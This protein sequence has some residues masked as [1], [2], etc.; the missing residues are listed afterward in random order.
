MRRRFRPVL[1]L[2]VAGL[3]AGHSLAWAAPPRSM[4]FHKQVAMDRQGFGI[5]AFRLLVPEK[6]RFQGGVTWDMQKFP[7]LATIAFK[8]ASPDG[9]SLFEHF[10]H[11]NFFWSQDPNLQMS[12]ART[13]TE[14]MAPVSAVDF[15]RNVFLPRHRKDIGDLKVLESAALPELARK[16][17]EIAEHQMAL[18][19]TISPFTFRFE[20]ASDAGHLRVQ[21][22][23][24]GRVIVEE[25]TVA[26]TRMTA[27]LQGM[28]GPVTSVTWIT[29]VNS[30]QAPAEEMAGRA[31]L[32]RVMLDS[33]LENPAWA[34]AGTRLAATVTREQLRHQQAVF[35]RMQQI[36][37]S[38]QEVSDMIV[39]GYRQRSAAQDRIF[40]KYSEA[41][42]GVDTYR[43]PVND[44]EIQL[45]TG[46]RNAWTDGSEYVFSDQ[47]DF[48]PNVGSNKNWQRMER[49]R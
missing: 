9:R 35:D 28:Y 4:R 29:Q 11:E 36:R 14:I 8:A 33:Y 42:R 25:L 20:L 6:W 18:F 47:S 21:Y 44:R 48:N 13:G 24:Q 16:T 15:L 19:H 49:K 40:D 2:V 1:L 43:D 32:F 27:Y 26:V 41:V 34:E 38:Q 46:M 45:P 31:P 30:F 22:R 39:K 23:R 37:R 10:P 3:L 17:R 5:E 12:Y 7:P